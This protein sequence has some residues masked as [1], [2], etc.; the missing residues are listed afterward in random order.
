MPCDTVIQRNQTREQRKA[1]VKKT[2]TT[3]QNAIVAK[4]VRVKVGPQGAIAFDGI[5]NRAGL[6]DACIYRMIM[7][8]GTALAKAEIARAEQ[9]AGVSVNRQTLAHGIH[10]HDG[11]KTWHGKG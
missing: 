2:L 3:I 7:I 9:I 6:S 10:S 11:G 5:E 1:E 8:S 4:T